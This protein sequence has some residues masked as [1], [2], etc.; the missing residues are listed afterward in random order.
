MGWLQ[1]VAHTLESIGS[2]IIAFVV[3]SV[4]EKVRTQRAIDEAVVLEMEREEVAVI[5]SIIVLGL[6]WALSIADSVHHIYL[7]QRKKQVNQMVTLGHLSNKN[8]IDVMQKQ[9]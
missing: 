4:H 9:Q 6:G 1:V 7:D 5:V 3:L 8:E 2:L